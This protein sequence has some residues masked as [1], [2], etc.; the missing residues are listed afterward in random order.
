MTGDSLPGQ[1]PSFTAVRIQLRGEVQGLGVRPAVANLAS[2]CG[3]HGFVAN[4]GS[5]VEVVVEGSTSDVADFRQQLASA[6]P[7][8]ATVQS[9][10]SLLLPTAGFTK[11]SIL[12]GGRAHCPAAPIP[13]DRSVCGDCLSEALSTEGR[14]SGYAFT[15]CTKCGPRFSILTGMPY[16]RSATSMRGFRLCPPCLKEFCDPDDRRFHAQTNAC[17]Q[18]GPRFWSTDPSGMRIESPPDPVRSAIQILQEGGIVALCGLG[19]YQLLCDATSES[20]VRRL[21]AGKRRPEKPFAILV[22]DL[23]S[24][25]ANSGISDP[26]RSLLSDA[27]NPIVIVGPHDFSLAPAV[28]CGV[29]SVGILLPT[30][31][32]HALLVRECDRPLVVTS[33]NEDGDPLA[34]SPDDAQRQLSSIADLLLHH[35]RPSC[36]RLMTAWPESWPAARSP[37]GPLG[38]S[39]PFRSRSQGRFPESP[40]VA[41]RKSPLPWPTGPRP[42]W[43]RTSAI[44]IQSSC[45]R[46]SNPIWAKCSSSTASTPPCS[47]AISIPIISPA[48]GW[49]HLAITK[50]R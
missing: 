36:M 1:A 29:R 25:V 22:P 49:N 42:P 33:G 17:A 23:P 32:L 47:S 21:R 48:A 45:G 13:R 31:P 35:D 3:V 8:E 20:A 41:I 37:C 18:C 24:V 16:E 30:T 44:L 40:S 7:R 14:R 43:G 27:A 19:G 4:I 6:L 38:D 12:E 9:S 34:A 39:R 2:R 10:E 15:S 28:C 46:G 50:S 26:E 5:G 11:F